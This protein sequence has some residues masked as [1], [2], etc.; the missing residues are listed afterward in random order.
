MT[1]RRRTSGTAGIIATLCLALSG[2][3][4]IPFIG[5]GETE[6]PPE[7]E[8]PPIVLD[9]S[10]VKAVIPGPQPG[11]DEQ[12]VA[13]EVP[14][15]YRKTD[16]ASCIDVLM[17]GQAHRTLKQ[18]E[19]SRA[20]RR[21]TTG[22]GPSYQELSVQVFSHTE[23][24]G[25]AL[26]DRANAALGGCEAFAF[27]GEQAGQSID[28][29]YSASALDIAPLGQQSFAVRLETVLA[30]SRGR[31]QEY[32]FDRLVVREGN[33]LVVTTLTHLD[34][35]RDISL[36]RSTAEQTLTNLGDQ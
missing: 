15:R 2:C 9:E 23:P 1:T 32:S 6:Q 35:D 10:Q 17:L 31:P 25:P 16:P 7:R 21:F 36:L 24:V 20:E 14:A 19:N 27:Y 28:D 33:T 34:P 22:T 8:V 26:V 12:D 13:E 4:T 3:G 11:W 30:D 18:R 5:D 29:R